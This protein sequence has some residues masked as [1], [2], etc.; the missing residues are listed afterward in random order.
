MMGGGVAVS[1]CCA[2]AGVVTLAIS[3]ANDSAQI[4]IQLKIL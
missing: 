2:L 4:I 1:T 3:G